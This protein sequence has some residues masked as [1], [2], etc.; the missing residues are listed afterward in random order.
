MPGQLRESKEEEFE[1]LLEAGSF[2]E[3]IRENSEI[4]TSALLIKTFENG[5][6]KS[7][8]TP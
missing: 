4:L 2:I 1:V 5:F 8:F 7:L 6:L 3:G